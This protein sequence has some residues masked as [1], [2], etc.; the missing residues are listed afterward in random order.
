[1]M[2]KT[3]IA[4]V[5]RRNVAIK[6]AFVENDELDAGVRGLLNFGHTVGHA[7][8]LLSDYGVP[9]GNAVA[10]GMTVITRAAEKGGL[11]ESPCLGELRAALRRQ[12]LPDECPFSAPELAAAAMRDKKRSGDSIALVVP[13]EVGRARFHEIPVSRLEAFIASGLE[14]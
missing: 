2:G 4:E 1:M 9:H 3:P 12:G 10:I 13:V 7:I 8:E 5:C 6:A 14:E 11:T